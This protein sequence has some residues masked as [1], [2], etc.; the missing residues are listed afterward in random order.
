M[1]IN[2]TLRLNDS[3]FYPV[4][5]NKTMI[6]LHHTAGGS[7]KGA[8]NWWNT[9]PQKIGTAYL[10]ERDGTVY[11]CF[12]PKHYGFHVGLKGDD[13]YVESHSVGIEIVAYGPLQKEG[14][15][16]VFYPAWP[17][18]VNPKV[19]PAADVETLDTPWRGH[20]YFHKYTIAQI[21]ATCD[22][23][24]HLIATFKMPITSL[25][26]KFL[27]FNPNFAK[28]RKPGIWSHSTARSDK[29]DI[30]PSLDMQ[31]GLLTLFE[32]NKGLQGTSEV[33]HPSRMR[34]HAKD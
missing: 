1:Q 22:L 34:K 20:L 24:R 31:V 4:E 32:E 30:Y 3:Q 27:D 17:L 25:D 9:T 18:K 5:R 10:I 7:A 11:E 23:I 26:P 16:F 15:K 19:I 6:M 8:I 14:D 28:E 21:A 2:R 12:D 13:N 29:S 33:K